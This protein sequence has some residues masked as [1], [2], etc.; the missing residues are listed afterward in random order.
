MTWQ[1]PQYP[2]VRDDFTFQKNINQLT[3]LITP[4]INRIIGYVCTFEKSFKNV[5]QSFQLKNILSTDFIL[6]VTTEKYKSHQQ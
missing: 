5:T 1:H 2:S 4:A 3:R 6:K